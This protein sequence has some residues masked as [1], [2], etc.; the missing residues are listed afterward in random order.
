MKIIHPDIYDASLS[1]N[2]T[3]EILSDSKNPVDEDMLINLVA[4]YFYC[5]FFPDLV[6]AKVSIQDVERLFHRG[7]M[8]CVAS[9][10]DQHILSFK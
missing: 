1:L 2:Q 7:N 4:K 5:Y 8:F 10:E 3:I 9:R 6:D